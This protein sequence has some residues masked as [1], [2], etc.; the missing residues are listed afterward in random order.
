MSTLGS[1][2]ERVDNISRDSPNEKSETT[3]LLAVLQVSN[4][5]GDIVDSGV[6]RQAITPHRVGGWLAIIIA[7]FDQKAKMSAFLFFSPPSPT[8]QAWII[9]N[10]G[11]FGLAGLP[12]GDFLGCYCRNVVLWGCIFD[13]LAVLGVMFFSVRGAPQIMANN[14]WSYATF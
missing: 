6:P 12:P 10:G 2:G 14:V 11:S 4:Y 5:I 9:F 1:N 8:W 13:F 3:N 7:S